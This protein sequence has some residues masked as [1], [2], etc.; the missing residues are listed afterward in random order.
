[1]SEIEQLE[2]QVE[3]LSAEDF[4][5]FRAW[6]IEFDS[7]HWDQQIK[8]HL[9][10]GRLDNLIAE[11]LEDLKAGSARAALEGEEDSE[12]RLARLERQGLLR[13]ASAPLSGDDLMTPLPQPMEGAS[14]L[15]ALL[16][17][18]REGR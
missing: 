13:R 11:A 9:K 16:A 4:A 3:N 8:Q 5:R 15:N 7:R 17:E 1:M 12:G 6:F 14:V 10:A 18:R 2:Q